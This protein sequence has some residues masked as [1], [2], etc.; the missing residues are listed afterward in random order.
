MVGPKDW[1][2]FKRVEAFLQQDIQFEVLEGLQG[3]F[4]G[5]RPRQPLN[6]ATV[7]TGKVKKQ[8]KKLSQKPVK[9]DKSFYQNVAVGDSVFIP[10]KKTA[11][12]PDD[13]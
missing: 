2:S 13:E 11:P 10:K 4:T 6:K 5:L 8:V 7:S 12:K 9:R 1:D 3:K